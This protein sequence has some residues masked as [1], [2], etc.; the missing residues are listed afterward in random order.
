LHLHLI[1]PLR[2]FRSQQHRY[3]DAYM[4][5]SRSRFIPDAILDLFEHRAWPTKIAVGETLP[6]P[7]FRTDIAARLREMW[8]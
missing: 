4:F 5:S 8:E 2:F 3:G 6:K 1:Q 7:E